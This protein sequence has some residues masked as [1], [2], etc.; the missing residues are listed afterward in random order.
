M[1]CTIFHFPPLGFTDATESDPFLAY[2]ISLKHKLSLENPKGIDFSCKKFARVSRIG[3]GFRN[4]T[5]RIATDVLEVKN[6]HSPVIVAESLGLLK[7]LIDHDILVLA[8]QSFWSEVAED[9]KDDYP[10]QIGSLFLYHW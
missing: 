7:E 3:Q 4:I 10:Y 1:V 8:G 5:H 2:I 6:V 9:T